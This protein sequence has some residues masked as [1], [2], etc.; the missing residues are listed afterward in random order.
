M[1]AA[2]TPP[3][4]AVSRLPSWVRRAAPWV[5]TVLAALVGAWLALVVA[6]TTHAAVGPFG[7]DAAI[8]PAWG[9]ETVLE[10]D[11]IGTLVLDTHNA[12]LEVGVSVRTVD[13]ERV[14]DIVNDPTSLSG[15]DDRVVED[16]QDVLLR[17]AVRAA[18]VALIGALVVGGLVLRSW[19]RALIAGA[20][21]L[22]IVAGSY[23]LA[24]LTFD[25]DAVR[26]PRF[27]G[28]LT[29]AP[30]L[31]GSAEAIAS[32]FDAYADQ[33][34]SIV[35]NVGR[36]YD[37]ALTLPTFA[38]D[39]DTI[40]LM[41]VSDLHLNPSAWDV[42]RAVAEQYDVDVIVDTGDIADHGTGPESAYVTPIAGLGRPY[43][44]VKGNHDS[45]VTQAAVA[46]N[47]NAVVLAG[48]P[49][50]VAGL[51]FIGAPDPRFTP[52]QTTRGTADQ[53]LR[54]STEELAD[55]ARSLDPHADILVFHD[56]TY[57]E[58]FDGAAPLVL[59]GHAHRRQT[60]VLDE[61]TRVMV[62][63]STGGAG[64]RALEGEDPTPV[65]LSVLYLNPESRQLVAWDD[66]TLGGLGLTSAEIQRHL[67]D[68]DNDD[69]ASD[70]GDS[71]D[72][73]DA[74]RPDEGTTS[75]PSPSP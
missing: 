10:V 51:T 27:T 35:T 46:E 17:A 19:R 15:I 68:E 14:R 70:N 60:V 71:D 54:R 72:G 20:V 28:L 74:G 7:V 9:G 38:P 49:V 42:I 12:P 26:E 56:P 52:D 37:T 1:I 53:D 5:A 29:T 65:T 75:S 6:G 18:V 30:Q 2:S 57:A 58:L 50:D 41:H 16:L 59:A 25:R 64:L 22:G 36:L 40:R 66:I 73:G 11:P 31:V 55:E 62:Q 32:N 45:I 24:A 13:V 69:G 43:V 48:D 47:A 3:T 33:L 23:G 21:A 63:G 67:A 44:F 39:D 8:K 61:G 34:A 4:P